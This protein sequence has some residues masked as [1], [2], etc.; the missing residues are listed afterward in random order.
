MVLCLIFVHLFLVLR[1]GVFLGCVRHVC[2][3]IHGQNFIVDCKTTVWFV[4][5]KPNRDR[6]HTSGRALD[7]DVIC[8]IRY[9]RFVLYPMLEVSLSLY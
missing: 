2:I 4:M 9:L 1:V 3:A 7:S 6:A 8:D 5:L